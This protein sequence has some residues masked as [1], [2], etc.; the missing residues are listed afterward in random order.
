MFFFDYTRGGWLR[1]LITKPIGKLLIRIMPNEFHPVP[2]G[3]MS[4]IAQGKTPVFH[5]AP[6]LILMVED[7][8]GVPSPPMDIGICGQNMVL[9]AHS[10]GAGSCWIGL[11]KLL[12]YMPWWKKRFG[13]RYPYRLDV[14]IAARV[15]EA[16]GRR[17]RSARG[18][19]SSNGLTAASMTRRDRRAGGMT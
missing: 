1:R 9:A 16:E 5:N 8:R 14:C 19:R 11:I 13:I 3:L 2:F 7:R 18:R 17:D 4:Q 12:M 10:L 15:A 6:T